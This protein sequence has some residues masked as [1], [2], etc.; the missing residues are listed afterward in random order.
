MSLAKKMRR[1]EFIWLVI[2]WFYNSHHRIRIE[3]ILPLF[4]A[5]FDIDFQY[6]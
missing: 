4:F 2:D 5:G 3:W 1:D 6:E